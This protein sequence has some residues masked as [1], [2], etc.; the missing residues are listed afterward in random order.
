MADS[1]LDSIKKS[2][3]IAT[4]DD[5]FDSDIKLHANAALGILVQNGIGK[6][7]TISDGS[8]TWDDFKDDTQ[9]N[10][11]QLFE[12]IP[13]YVFVYVKILFDPP[14]AAASLKAY[15]ATCD[16]LLWRLNVE[17]DTDARIKEG[18]SNELL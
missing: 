8:E 18:E 2:L 7:L 11:N 10:G 13:Q 5:S 9:V 3:D 15:R 17:Y 14:A 16:E 4:D 12:L 6:R 1:I